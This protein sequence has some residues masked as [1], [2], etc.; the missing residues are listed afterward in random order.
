MFDS[1]EM[2]DIT[3]DLSKINKTSRLNSNNNKLE[4]NIYHKMKGKTTLTRRTQNKE[5]QSTITSNSTIKGKNNVN[6]P[7]KFITT[8]LLYFS[9]QKKSIRINHFLCVQF[10]YHLIMKFC[11]SIFDKTQSLIQFSNWILFKVL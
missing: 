9:H 1:C 10:F 3:S 6:S 7:Y 8:Y 4:E 2:S 5:G 11:F